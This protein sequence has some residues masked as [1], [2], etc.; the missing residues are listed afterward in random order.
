M[1]KS[2]GR[3]I[4]GSLLLTGALL[5]GTA[6]AKTIMVNAGQSIQA[7]VDVASPGDIVMVKPGTYHEAGRPCPSDPTK[8]CAVAITADN[9]RL[10]AQSSVP[11][12][13]ILENAGG[14][15]RGIE[16]ARNGVSGRNLLRGPSPADCGQPHRRVHRERV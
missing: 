9:I 5:N 10:V 12:P 3:G 7:A 14:H 2:L 11:K 8:S 16:V 1:R 4:L 6:V 13:V 15:D